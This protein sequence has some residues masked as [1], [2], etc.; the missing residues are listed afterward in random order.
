MDILTKGCIGRWL[1]KRLKQGTCLVTSVGVLLG[2]DFAYAL[3]V[4][5]VRPQVASLVSSPSR[6]ELK[7]G[8][9]HCQMA[10]NLIWEAPKAANYCLWYKDQRRPIKCWHNSWHGSVKVA[11]NANSKTYFVLKPQTSENILV[12][13]SISVTGTY[14]QR[15]R[16]QRRKRGIWRMF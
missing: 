8:Q 14:K 16:A 5:N 12:Q 4:D 6:C 15:K 9:K 7:S 10:V 2:A 13:T 1:S 11:F 3:P